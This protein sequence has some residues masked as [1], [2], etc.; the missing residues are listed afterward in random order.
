MERCEISH[1]VALSPN[2]QNISAVNLEAG[3]KEEYQHHIYGHFKPHKPRK[4]CSTFTVNIAK[5]CN[6]RHQLYTIK[7][8]NQG[9]QIMEGI[10]SLNVLNIK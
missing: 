5:R 10:A 6:I 8:I 1:N 2:T 3:E 4:S 7:F 9:H